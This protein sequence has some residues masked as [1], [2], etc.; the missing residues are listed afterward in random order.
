MR[1][2]EQYNL[3][4][5]VACRVAIVDGTELRRAIN[6]FKNNFCVSQARNA[7]HQAEQALQLAFISTTAPKSN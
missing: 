7:F 3:H 4:A 2:S 5:A 6:N 1:V